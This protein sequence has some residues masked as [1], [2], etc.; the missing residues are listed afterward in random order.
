[1]AD[2]L[3]ILAGVSAACGSAALR[4]AWSLHRR[5][6]L[7][8]AA[9]WGLFLL[10]VLAGWWGAGAWGVSVASLVGMSAALLILSHAAITSPAA[11][12]AKASNRRVGMLPERGE[13]L[14]LRR[15]LMTFLIVVILAMIVS[16]GLGIAA[17][18][19]MALTGAAEANS[20]VTGFFVTPLAWSILAYALLIEERRIRQW[21]TLGIL[22]VP[23]ALALIFGLSA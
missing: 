15:R 14:H 2:T 19:L 21:A 12:N 3:L 8:N 11:A 10:G 23:G 20:V 17:Y 9:G 16:T 7:W 22:A 18:G 13:P 5:S 4:H 6:S 1:M